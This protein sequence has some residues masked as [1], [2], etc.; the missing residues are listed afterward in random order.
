[1]A[2]AAP[3]RHGGVVR[4]HEPGG[5]QGGDGR[6]ADRVRRLGGP[7]R[8]S[9]T[10]AS[11][12]DHR[13]P[14]GAHARSCRT[15]SGR[16]RMSASSTGPRDEPRCR[17]LPS[18]SRRHG[19]A[20]GPGRCPHRGCSTP[21]AGTPYIEPRRRP[22]PLGAAGPRAG[23]PGGAAASCSPPASRTGS[24]RTPERARLEV[25]ASAP[26]RVRPRRWL[27]DRGRRGAPRAIVAL[28]RAT[29]ATTSPDAC[30]SSAG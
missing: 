14:A 21:A 15:T 10:W 6:G 27:D 4:V 28:A 17:G 29:T 2:V 22:G 1:M 19:P 24:P 25:P 12:H 11:R 30:R 9:A 8:G 5:H 26:V 7:R 23:P 3:R 20:A 18:S 16:A 13:R